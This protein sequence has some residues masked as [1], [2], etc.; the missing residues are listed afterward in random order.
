MWLR[1]FAAS[2]LLIVIAAPP[3]VRAG[4]TPGVA[5]PYEDLIEVLAILTWHMRDDAYRFPAPKDPTGRDVYK[6]ALARLQSWEKRF[7]GRMLDVTTLG[8][9]QALERLGEF[10]R[11]RAAYAE[12]EGMTTS[13]LARKGR[14]GAERATAFAEAAALPEG[15]DGVDEE[16]SSLRRKLDAWGALVE[17]YKDTPYGAMALVE[18]E[19]LERATTRLVVDHRRDLERGNETAEKALRFLIEKHADSKLLPAHILRLGDFYAE[20]ARQYVSEHER[21]LSFDE[22]A[23]TSLT[24]RALDTYHKVAAWDGAREKP[25]AQARFAALEAWK[26][27]TLTRYR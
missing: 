23:F 12:V 15:G 26:R 8:R 14:E 24:D 13:P 11:A 17:R 5:A 20:L 1:L 25:E 4:D 9:A 27:A 18:E 19:R 16:L 10:D 21:P 3:A 6:L 2:A 7:P 22:D